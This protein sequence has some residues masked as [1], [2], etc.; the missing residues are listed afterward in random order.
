MRESSQEAIKVLMKARIAEMEESEEIKNFEEA[1]ELKDE[2]FAGIEEP[3]KSQLKDFANNL[4]EARHI[5]I[6]VNSLNDDKNK[7]HD[8]NIARVFATAAQ[9]LKSEKSAI[10]ETNKK[11]AIYPEG[12]IVSK[13]DEAVKSSFVY[14]TKIL[15]KKGITKIKESKEIKNFEEAYELKDK[16]FAGIEEPDKSE[17]KDFANGTLRM[18]YISN[19]RSSVIGEI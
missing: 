1:Y 17:L 13:I 4:L 8:L 6:K 14:F 11:F 3:D 12:K 15:I 18:S 16:D 7:Q 2:D 19:A 10:L 9:K 5:T